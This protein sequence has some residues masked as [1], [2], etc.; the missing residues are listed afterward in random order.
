MN[1]LNPKFDKLEITVAK[2][3]STIFHPILIPTYLYL[4]LIYFASAHTLQIPAPMEWVLGVI[5]FATT[6]VLP[7]TILLLMI[8][9]KLISSLMLSKRIERTGPI[10][11]AAIFLFL[12][13][14]LFDYMGFMPVFSYFLLCSSSISLVTMMINSFWKISL[15]TTGYGALL[16]TYLSLASFIELPMGFIALIIIVI[17]IIASSRLKLKAHSPAEI[18]IGFA[19]GY[20]TMLLF[21]LMI[22]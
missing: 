10:L 20:T 11:V 18:Y 12:T 2:V 3:I 14:Y 16:A 19:L 15:H 5:I 21:F 1:E 22:L 7:T 17:G 4:S 8:K 9:F 13:Y 6:F